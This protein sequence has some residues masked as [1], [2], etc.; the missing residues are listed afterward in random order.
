MALEVGGLRHR[1]ISSLVS[2]SST[3]S[4]RRRPTRDGKAIG[5]AAALFFN[6]LFLPNIDPL[7]RTLA[8]LATYSVGFVAPAI[9]SA[10]RSCL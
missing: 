8:S 7:A 10:A 9:G 5:P 2:M 6:I 4:K 3:R 1:M